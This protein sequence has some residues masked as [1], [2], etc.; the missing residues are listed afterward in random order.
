MNK[1]AVL[2]PMLFIFALQRT[3]GTLQ[4]SKRDLKLNVT[5]QLHCCQLVEQERI[6]I[7]V[8]ESTEIF[9]DAANRKNLSTSLCLT[10]T[11]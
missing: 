8:K 4:F 7:Y 2:S 1:V 11:T 6:Y 5:E 3:S 9:V 10:R